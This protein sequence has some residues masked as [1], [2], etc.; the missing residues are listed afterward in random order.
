MIQGCYTNQR[1]TENSDKAKHS[2][3]EKRRNCNRRMDGE[4]PDQRIRNRA[5]SRDEGDRDQNME[6]AVMGIKSFANPHVTWLC[7]DA[8]FLKKKM[9]CDDRQT[10]RE[11]GEG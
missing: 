1:R 3:R 4:N 7:T 11:K 8:N 10:G 2:I 9:M 6:A 5:G